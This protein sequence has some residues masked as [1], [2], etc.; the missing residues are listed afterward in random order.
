MSDGEPG[1]FPGHRIVAASW[2]STVVFGSVVALHLLATDRLQGA[3]I[4][5]SLAFFVLGLL[6]WMYAFGKAVARS[7]RDEIT[8]TGLFFL[9]RTAPRPVQVQMLSS[10]LVALGAAALSASAQPFAV[11]EPVLPLALCGLWGA[12]HGRFGPRRQPP[13][14]PSRARRQGGARAAGRK[15]AGRR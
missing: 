9:Q 6:V 5:V 14:R 15:G 3:S 7:T 13:P 8:L 4:A 1:P 11:M 12:R 10:L 2:L